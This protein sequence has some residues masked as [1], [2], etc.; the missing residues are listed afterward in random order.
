MSRVNKE[1]RK[2]NPEK[3]K[4]H[5]MVSNAIRYGKLSRKPCEKC[6]NPKSHAHHSDYSKPLAIEW[7]CHRCHWET[8]GWVSRKQ[9]DKVVRDKGNGELTTRPVPW[10]SKKVNLLDQA[11][12]LRKAGK[13]YKEI[14][15]LLNTTKSTVYKWLNDCAYN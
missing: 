3:V 6:G 2:R 4:A 14:A 5:W 12:E 10:N 8:H 13:S 15:D 7:L 11:R 1:W 9:K